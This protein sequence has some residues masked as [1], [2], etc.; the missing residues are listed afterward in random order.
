MDDDDADYMQGSD[1]EVV[2]PSRLALGRY[3]DPELFYRITV[4]TTLM[5]MRPTS[6]EVLM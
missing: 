1:D 2:L 4:S 5:E 6:P 3:A